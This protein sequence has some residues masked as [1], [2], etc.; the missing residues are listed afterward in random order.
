MREVCCTCSRN[1]WTVASS[2]ATRLSSTR[3]YA[4]A[5]GGIRSHIS[6]G[7][8]IWLSMGQ[9]YMRHRR[10][11]ARVSRSDH[12]NAYKNKTVLTKEPSK[13]RQTLPN[14]AKPK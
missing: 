4:C 12:V 7:K 3:M 1:G 14:K 8:G 6:G 9:E 11:L 2:T 5:S 13:K 10:C